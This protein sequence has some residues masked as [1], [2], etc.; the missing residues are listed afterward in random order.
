MK[1]SAVTGSPLDHLAFLRSLKTQVCGSTC[2]QLSA[3]PG[4]ILPFASAAHSPSNMSRI[5]LL[6]GTPVASAA[7]RVSGSEPLL[8]TSS[9]V[10][11]SFTPAGTVAAAAR[12]AEASST[13]HASAFIVQ[14]EFMFVALPDKN[15]RACGPPW[16]MER[17]GL[18]WKTGRLAC[19]SARIYRR[20]QRR[21]VGSNP[22]A[23]SMPCLA[24]PAAW[25]HPAHLLTTGGRLPLGQKKARP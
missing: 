17:L 22:S 25:I 5:T 7:S 16:L 18:P 9:C 4:T 15:W 6:A 24:A 21:L 14:F 20:P 10:S 23:I 12:P 1:S 8:R 19:Q 2:F 11:C 13:A 3:T